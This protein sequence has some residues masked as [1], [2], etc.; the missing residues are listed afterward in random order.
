MERTG[1]NVREYMYLGPLHQVFNAKG[2]ELFGR[3][4][5]DEATSNAQ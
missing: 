5:N 2:C 3:W 1:A 4:Q